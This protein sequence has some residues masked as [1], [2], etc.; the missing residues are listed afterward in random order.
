MTDKARLLFIGTAEFAL[1]ILQML[2]RRE[3]IELVGVITQSDKP[4]G[5]GNEMKM[6]PVKQYLLETKF[7]DS[8]IL[9][10]EKLKAE[11]AAILESTR[12]DLIIAAAYGQIVPK[13]MLD[14]PKLGA[15]NIHG[16]LL[17]Q[18]RGAVPVE[19]AIWQGLTVTGVTLQFMSEKMDEGD[20]VAQK[21]VAI[22]EDET[23]M[24]L[25]ARLADLGAEL[26][27]AQLPALL[28]NTAPRQSQE[29][30]H[31]TYCYERDIAKEKA[32]IKFETPAA[33]AERMVRALQPWPVAWVN[34]QFQGRL[35]RLKIFQAVVAKD[36]QVPVT[37]KLTVTR[38]GKKLFLQL[39]NGNL[40]LLELQLEG[41]KRDV[42]A[43]Y[44][45][46]S[47]G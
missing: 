34:I 38:F 10:P 42:A 12:P 16:S 13:E 15:L 17:P 29:H 39:E 7:P 4:A 2:Q 3:D 35:Q 43:N 8:H 27:Q 1:P 20:I 11:A 14:F 40:E 24:E 36:D 45:F 9:Q 19:M 47:L 41:K 46:L 32:E 30:E 26:L 37:D 6:S 31:A 25:K 23:A 5:R 18:L 21:A 33:E 22:R 28:N 44:L